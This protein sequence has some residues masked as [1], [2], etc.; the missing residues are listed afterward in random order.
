LVLPGFAYSRQ[1]RL[2]LKIK[3]GR[4]RPEF[5]GSP[6]RLDHSFPLQVQANLDAAGV[7]TRRPVDI[8]LRRKVMPFNAVTQLT[9]AAVQCCHPSD[10]PAQ[11]TL[12]ENGKSP[13]RFA[14]RLME[15]MDRFSDIRVRPIPF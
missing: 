7:K 3:T 8:L 5:K 11:A 12:S 14:R 13:G 1:L 9:E 4:Q 10:T 6:L 2:I 15:G